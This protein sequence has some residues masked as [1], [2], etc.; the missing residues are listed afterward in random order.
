MPA[1]KK[2]T[3]KQPKREGLFRVFPVTPIK[4][5]LLFLG[6]FAVLGGALAVYRS[7]AFSWQHVFDDPDFT[8]SACNAGYDPP[9]GYT[10]HWAI[11]KKTTAKV[12]QAFIS[13][14]NGSTTNAHDFGSNPY[15]YPVTLT[16][17]S[18][19]YGLLYKVDAAS[20][21]S[22]IIAGL[23]PSTLVSCNGVRK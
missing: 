14:P 11:L 2:T 18:G 21:R 12:T 20:V 17:N 7:F 9:D 23:N 22:K 5:I 10:T 4:G 16:A 15:V 19:T 13:A 1:K 6:V 8:I 3:T